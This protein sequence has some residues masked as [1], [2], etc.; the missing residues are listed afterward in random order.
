MKLKL[1][2]AEHKRLTTTNISATFEHLSYLLD[3]PEEITKI[4]DGAIVFTPTGDPWV[5]E[6]N[7]I[8]ANQA[9]SEGAVVH[10]SQPLPTTNILK[11]T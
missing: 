1:N 5:D 3:H 11:T 8:L 7:S 9:K 6:Q 2:K 4:P 10:Y